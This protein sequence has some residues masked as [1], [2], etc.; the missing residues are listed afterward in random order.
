MDKV[1]EIDETILKTVDLS[2]TTGFNALI[3]KEVNTKQLIKKHVGV[4]A[5]KV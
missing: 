1:L 2:W 5:I 3:I 4:G